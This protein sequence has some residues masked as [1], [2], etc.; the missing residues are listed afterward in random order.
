MSRTADEARRA[1]LLDRA[2]D[3]VCRH[4]LAELSLRPLA[5]A[6]GSSPRVLLYYFG[7]KEELVVEI[8]RHGRARQRVMM[9]HLKLTD[10]SPRSVAR[11][12]WR[13]WSKPEW[14]ALTRLSFE[15]YTLALQDRLRFPGFLE[16]SVNEWLEALEVCTTLPGYTRDDARALGTLLIAGFRGFLLDLFATH[17]RRR[18]DRAVD[19]WL[20]LLYDTPAHERSVD[21]AAG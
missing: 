20:S 7:S 14:E 5:K 11:T 19:L 6:V 10:L 4:G 1:E 15:T 13:E 18:V 21:D 3:Y 17:D 12:L 16:S 9:A 2:V 8:V